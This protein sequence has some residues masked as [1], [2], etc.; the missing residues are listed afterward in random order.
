M[1]GGLKSKMAGALGRAGE[2]ADGLAVAEG[3]IAR[4]EQ[5]EGRWAIAE[6]L[7]VKGELLL[8]QGAQ[9]AA[10][11]A[12]DHFRHAFYW[13]RR[14]GALSWELRAATE[15]H[16]AAAR[17]EPCRRRL[18]A[19]PAHLRPVHRG[20]RHGRSQSRKGTDRIVRLTSMEQKHPRAEHAIT[21][22]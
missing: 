17:S 3:A 7:R 18:A 5:I 22:R 1:G 21:L 11:E 15:P 8:L 13:A 6:L 10:A 12:E 9:G 20:F 19:P 14:Q 2:I 4:A 16:P